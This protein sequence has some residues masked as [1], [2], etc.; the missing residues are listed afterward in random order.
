MEAR[1]NQALCASNVTP[2]ELPVG[3]F[4]RGFSAVRRVRELISLAS[5]EISFSTVVYFSVIARL[6][7]PFG[8]YEKNSSQ[9]GERVHGHARA[10][11][12]RYFEG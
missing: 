5:R 7:H 6:I 8:F 1:I 12:W 2:I 10:C 4:T 3:V 9:F 11:S